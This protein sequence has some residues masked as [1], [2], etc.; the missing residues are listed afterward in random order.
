MTLEVRVLVSGRLEMTHHVDL[1]GKGHQARQVKPWTWSKILHVELA[2]LAK[3]KS[4][5]KS[6][7]LK[8]LL[9]I[10]LLYSCISAT[11]F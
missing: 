5:E 10:C 4:Y 3:T 1:L 9:Q 2:S 7:D 8:F 6:K 11:E